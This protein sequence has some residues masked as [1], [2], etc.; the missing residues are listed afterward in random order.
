MMP[1]NHHILDGATL[2]KMPDGTT[3]PLISELARLSNGGTGGRSLGAS[4]A[5]AAYVSYSTTFNDHL[6]PARGIGRQIAT[7]IDDP[8]IIHTELWATATPL[9]R[10]WYGPKLL[11]KLRAESFSIKTSPKEASIEIPKND[12][13]NDRFNLWT[14]KIQGMADAFEWGINDLVIA[15]YIAGIQGTALGT[16]YDGQNLFDTDHTALSIGG[17][18]QSNIVTGAFSA[19]VYQAAWQKYLTI[20]NE[21]GMP[22]NDPG[23][24]PYLVYGPANRDLVKAV[25]VVERQAGGAD[26]QNNPQFSGAASAI[27]LETGYIT[28]GRKITV[29]G[30]TITL[31]GLEWIMVKPGSASVIVQVKREPQLIVVDDPNS[32][33]MFL[34]AKVLAGIETEFGAGYGP[35]QDVVGGPGA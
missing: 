11:N 28:A 4:K 22:V 35:W 31:T 30:V 34:N 32:A 19:A 15:M 24:R 14:P 26:N 27:P 13:L 29:G 17:T 16:T 8:N 7:V 33:Y 18:Q 12:L 20:L 23:S 2:I 6:K 9:L 3:R 25:L 21:N 5:E 10:E 1:E